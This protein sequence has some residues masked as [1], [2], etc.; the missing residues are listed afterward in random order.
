MNMA[1]SQ[2]KSVRHNDL[3]SKEEAKYLDNWVVGYQTNGQGS[4]QNNYSSRK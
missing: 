4:N 3:D 2:G 1:S